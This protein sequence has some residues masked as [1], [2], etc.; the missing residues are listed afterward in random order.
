MPSSGAAGTGSKVRLK[1][2]P[3]LFHCKWTLYF[4]AYFVCITRSW[5]SAA[6]AAAGAD[7]NCP[8]PSV[9]FAARDDGIRMRFGEIVRSSTKCQCGIS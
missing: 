7:G 9:P 4:L 5:V 2:K 6:A 1:R 3:S 8:F